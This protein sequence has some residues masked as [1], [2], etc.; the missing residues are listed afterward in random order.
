MTDH[1]PAY[2]QSHTLAGDRLSFALDQQADQLMEKLD[3]SSD[4]SGRQAITLVKQ[5]NVTVVMFALKAG[6][7][8]DE[9]EADG[10]VT[11]QVLRGNA[12]VTF[13]DDTVDGAA[14]TLVSIGRGVAHSVEAADDSVVL[15][16]VSLAEG[17]S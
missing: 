13:G 7:A 11:V 2:L 4:R 17:A 6:H 1:T 16:T 8:L 3:Q 5:D 14:G 10:V 9:H 12:K 15:V